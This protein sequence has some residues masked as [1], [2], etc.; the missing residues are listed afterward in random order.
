MGEEDKDR[1]PIEPP[2]TK[3]SVTRTLAESAAQLSPPTAALARIYQD[4][5]PP[6]AERNRQA[7]EQDISERSNEQDARLDSHDRAL[8]PRTEKISGTTANLIAALAH[9]CPD[10]LRSKRYTLDELCKVLPNADPQEI[11][12]AVFDLV[13]VGLLAISR[14]SNGWHVRLEEGFYEQVDHQLFDWDTTKDAARLAREMIS[15][16]PLEQ[17]RALQAHVGWSKRRFNPAVAYLMP[18]IP[19]GRTRQSMQA[20]YPTMGFTL[21]DEDR[22]RLRRF[23]REIDEGE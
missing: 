17:M 23:A 18:E 11:N 14:H 7:W 19:Q 10:G 3:P 20:E 5:H 8:A 16:R 12:D 6:A 13:D 1:K 15:E 21:L 9:D 4:T 22:A 2:D